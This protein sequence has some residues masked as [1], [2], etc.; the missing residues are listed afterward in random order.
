MSDP[1]SSDDRTAHCQSKSQF[2]D[3][4]LGGKW[5]A[6]SSMPCSLR[7]T[8]LIQVTPVHDV[9]F[10]ETYLHPLA[11]DPSQQ[12]PEVRIFSEERCIENTQER[13]VTV[14]KERVVEKPVDRIKYFFLI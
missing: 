4:I 8:T 1:S 6:T 2:T 5:Q 10:A 7:T 13:I 11:G 12:G 9:D 14:P 3:S